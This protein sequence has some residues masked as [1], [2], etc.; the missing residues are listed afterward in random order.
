[1]KQLLKLSVALLLAV[2]LCGCNFSGAFNPASEITVVAREDGSGTRSAFTELIGTE[3]RDDA[4]GI[5]KDLT[6]KE[7][8]IAKQT[9]VMMNTVAVD[10]YAI[11]YI[12]FGSMN[13][14]VTAVAINGVQPVSENV[15]NG[16]YALSR[17]FNI[18]TKGEP[19]GLAAD[20]IAYILSAEGQAV[21]SASYIAVDAQALPYSGTRPEGKI[22]VAGSSSV[23]PVMEKLKE[24]YMLINPNATIE[25]QQSDSSAGMNGAKE[26]TCD[27]AMA[28]RDL[29]ESELAELTATRIALDGIAIIVNNSNPVTN[30]STQQV[31]SI[32]EG[33]TLYWSELL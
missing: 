28:S 11:G 8:I 16:S 4:L 23:T 2:T 26:G 7:A 29:K 12:S 3:Y 33:T 22:V 9:D 5:R 32:F 18:A 24:A 31:Q 17:P 21:I 20:F 1:M 14:T 25:I 30:L 27:I 15:I 6:T 13:S 19:T 10:N